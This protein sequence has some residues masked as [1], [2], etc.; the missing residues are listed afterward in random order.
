MP[1]IEKFFANQK[2]K[3]W[4]G[5]SLGGGA[6]AAF[7]VDPSSGT[8]DTYSGYESRKFTSGGTFTVDSGTSEVDILIVG[9]GGGGSAATY[10][11]QQRLQT[12]HAHERRMLDLPARTSWSARVRQATRAR[13]WIGGLR[14]RLSLRVPSPPTRW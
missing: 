8:P 14:I 13:A 1:R 6:A 9:G 12:R 7:A 3:D 4:T 11:I 2:V 5:G 10:I